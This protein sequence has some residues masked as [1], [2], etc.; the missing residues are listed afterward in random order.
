MWAHTTRPFGQLEWVKKI[1]IQRVEWIRKE[2]N[3]PFDEL[4]L[5]V[6]ACSRMPQVAHRHP[7]VFHERS[8]SNG[9]GTKN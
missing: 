3:N 2:I 9:M 5:M 7:G 1:E 6:A 8:L 4:G